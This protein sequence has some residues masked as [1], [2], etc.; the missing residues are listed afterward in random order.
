MG[1]ILFANN[2]SIVIVILKLL[3]HHTG[4]N[5]GGKKEKMAA[6]T[7]IRTVMILSPVLGVTWIFG[8]AVMSLDITS[9]TVTFVIH[10][11]FVLLNSSQGFF[12]LLTT[13]FW[14]Q[15][16]REI[17]SPSNCISVSACLDH[18]TGKKNLFIY[19]L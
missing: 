2:L 5:S 17:K 14:D 4:E 11:V 6:K 13:C 15:M 18:L 16:V 12:L 8:F 9:G 3:S 10:Y 19:S 7:I 1:V